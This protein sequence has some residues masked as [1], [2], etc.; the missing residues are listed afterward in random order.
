M[1][2]DYFTDKDL[3]NF[4]LE[5]HG[6]PKIGQKNCSFTIAVTTAHLMA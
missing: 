4:K 1:A 5:Q 3:I 2:L 6:E